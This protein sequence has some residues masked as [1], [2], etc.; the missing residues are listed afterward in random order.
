MQKFGVQAPVVS[1]EELFA[2]EPAFRSFA[3]RIVGGTYTPSD[4]S[5]D[6]LLFTQQLADALRGARRAVPVRP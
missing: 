1:R 2:I 5:G 3:H 6:A 4:E